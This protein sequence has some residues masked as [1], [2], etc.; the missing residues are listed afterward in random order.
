MAM[1]DNSFSISAGG[2]LT[3]TTI[4]PLNHTVALTYAA[5]SGTP[6]V[7]TVTVASDYVSIRTVVT[8]DAPVGGAYTDTKVRDPGNPSGT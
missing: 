8:P 3:T 6:P 5:V 2:I 1:R 7:V 4:I